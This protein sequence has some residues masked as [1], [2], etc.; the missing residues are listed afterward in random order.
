MD[1]NARTLDQILAE[2]APTYAPQ[3]ETIRRRQALIPQT[4]NADIEEAKARQSQAYED[5]L[6]GARRRGLGFSGIPLGE[7]AK[8]ASTVFAPEVL[9]A[10]ARGSE[11]ALSLEEALLG[12]QER[13]RAQ[14]DQIRQMELDRQ[15]QAEQQAENRRASAR[16]AAS[17]ASATYGALSSMMGGGQQSTGMSRKADGGFAFTDAQGNP[18]SAATYAQNQG[19]DIR[20]VIYQMGQAGDKY[21]QTVYNQ[22]INDPFIDRNLAQY[23]RQ[24]SPL[25]WGASIPRAARQSGSTN[26][27]ARNIFSQGPIRPVL[28]L[29]GR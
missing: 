7:Q 9:R 19:L 18:V 5:I 23:A 10:R 4:V 11:Q 8:Y 21:A 16:A 15:F 20:D 1:Y 17:Q 28:N 26:A 27:N 25:F 12:V 13:R 2:L 24:Y 29:G 6:G 3:E 14:A 22:M